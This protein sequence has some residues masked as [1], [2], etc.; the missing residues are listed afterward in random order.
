MCGIAGVVIKNPGSMNLVETISA[1]SAAL[2]HRGPDGEGFMTVANAQPEP[3]FGFLNQRFKR[4]DLTTFQ[5]NN[6]LK[7]LPMPQ[8]LLHTGACLLST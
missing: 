5:K 7:Q 6:L 1:M 8:L 2:K 3:C 4:T